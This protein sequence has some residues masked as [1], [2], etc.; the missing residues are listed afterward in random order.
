MAMAANGG[1]Y[2]GPVIAITKE[3]G[4]RDM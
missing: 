1:A 3:K 2:T 4:N